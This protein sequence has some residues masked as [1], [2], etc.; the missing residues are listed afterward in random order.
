VKSKALIMGVVRR[1]GIAELAPFVESMRTSG[2]RG[3]CV[4]FTTSVSSAT[5]QYLH[6]RGIRT[7]PFFYPAIKNHQ[8]LLYAWKFWR[9]ILSWISNR[10]IRLQL[11]R[12]VWDLVYL[13]FFFER[14]FLISHPEYTKV[15]LT[16]VR[17]VVFQENPFSWM[18]NQKGVFCFE[19][20]AGRKIGACESNSRMVREVFGKQGWND[21]ENCPVSCSGVIFG[22]REPLLIYLE[23]FLDLALTGEALRPSSGSDQGIHNYIVHRQNLPELKLINNEGPVF[24][25]GCVPRE[26]I[27]TNSRGKVL[28]PSGLAYPILH[29]YDRFPDLA[30]TL[31]AKYSRQATSWQA[32]TP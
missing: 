14:N 32:T 8:P 25:M 6:D 4:L 30:E 10:E 28:N 11:A 2:Y 18:G 7:I 31:L 13:R 20:H 12:M 21:L 16:D 9:C 26:S 5:L 23:R 27:Q 29:Q 22:T 1:L 24:T 19:E 3:D 17:D 15:L